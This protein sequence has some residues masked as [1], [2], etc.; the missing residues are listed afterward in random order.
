[1][2]YLWCRGHIFWGVI[3]MFQKQRIFDLHISK[4]GVPR[5]YVRILTFISRGPP[6][7]FLSERGPSG[8]F[9]FITSTL[10][11]S[12]KTMLSFFFSFQE[13]WIPR[14]LLKASFTRISAAYFCRLSPLFLPSKPTVLT[15]CSPPG[16]EPPPFSALSE[17]WETGR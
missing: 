14:K 13:L 1:M 7:P 12:V 3:F 2:T 5:E 9:M 4:A 15:Q 6:A 10:L 8:P 16:V 11:P 17:I